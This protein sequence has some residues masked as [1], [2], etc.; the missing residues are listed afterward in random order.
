MSDQTG[1]RNQNIGFQNF[2]VLSLGSRTRSRLLCFMSSRN[3]GPKKYFKVEIN[4][5]SCS[6]KDWSCVWSCS[7]W[8]ALRLWNYYISLPGLDDYQCS[9][10]F[11][12]N[13]G[14]CLMECPTQMLIL[15][16]C[17]M[18]DALWSMTSVEIGQGFHNRGKILKKP[19][20]LF[21][22]QNFVKA[23]HWIISSSMNL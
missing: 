6:V 1:S 17:L 13:R 14:L 10:L 5:L 7:M 11:G 18:N 3:F 8:W 20:W 16:F 21:V 12:K 23:F 4:L 19:L 2:E 15:F 9:T 22:F